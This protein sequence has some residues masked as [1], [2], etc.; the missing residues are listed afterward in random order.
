MEFQELRLGGKDMKAKLLQLDE[1]L[2]H[3]VAGVA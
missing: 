3:I 1:C 2:A